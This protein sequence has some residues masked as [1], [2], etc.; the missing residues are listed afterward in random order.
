M[1]KTRPS[2]ESELPLDFW[3]LQN[4]VGYNLHQAEIASYRSFISIFSEY[5]LTPKQCSVLILIGV[6]P[7]ISQSDIGTALNMDRATTM[8]VID[9]LQNRQLLYRQP[10]TTDRRKH[11]LNLSRKGAALLDELKKTA[12]VH[13]KHI[14]AGLTRKETAQLVSLLQKIRKAAGKA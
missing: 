10:S 11:A 4:L 1:K 14:T 3:E 2:P 5:R 6:N 12:L 13:D 7:G 9:L 8:A